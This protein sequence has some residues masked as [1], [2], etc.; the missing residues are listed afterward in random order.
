MYKSFKPEDL[1]TVLE[2]IS[3]A[4]IKLDT[5]AKY[6]AMNG[7]AAEILRRLGREP[8]Q[9]LGK[10]IWDLFPGL[11]GTILEQKIREMFEHD[12]HIEFEFF[13]PADQRWYEGRGYPS[14]QSAIVILRDITEKKAT[15][16]G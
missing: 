16:S 9:M 7:A 5:K 3:D 2:G 1:M 12:A 8:L 10:S 15:K 6:L 4:V 14:P 11:K 13:Y